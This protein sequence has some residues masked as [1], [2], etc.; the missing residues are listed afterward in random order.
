MLPVFVVK[1]LFDRDYDIAKMDGFGFVD[2]AHPTTR[3]QAL[4][5]IALL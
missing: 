2:G 1:G 4:D 5:A 3:E